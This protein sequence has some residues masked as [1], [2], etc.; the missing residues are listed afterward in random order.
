M[1]Y[2]TRTA[3]LPIAWMHERFRYGDL[4][5]VYEKSFRMASAKAFVA[6]MLDMMG[7]Q[8]EK[9]YAWGQSSREQ[10]DVHMQD[11]GAMTS[12]TPTPSTVESRRTRSSSS[13]SSSSPPVRQ[14]SA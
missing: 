6:D 1:R 3:R 14:C 9:L 13:T 11:G 8:M 7:E 10:F 12:A 5:L 4:K 2:A